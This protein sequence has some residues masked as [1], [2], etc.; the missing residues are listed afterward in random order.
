MPWYKSTIGRLR[1]IGFWEGVSFLVLLGVAMPL[2]YVYGEPAA[3]RVV[4]MAHGVLF[5]LY[6]GAALHAAWEQAWTWQR[7]GLVLAASLLPAGPFVVDARLLR[8]AGKA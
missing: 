3:V 5:V 1:V 4:G 6:V 8:G 7:T 2:K